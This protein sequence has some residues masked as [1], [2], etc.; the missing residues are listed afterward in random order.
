[1]QGIFKSILKSVVAIS[2][3]TLG[4]ISHAEVA[5][6]ALVKQTADEVLSI[7]KND[8]EIQAGNQKKLFALAEEKILPNFDFERVCK[9]VLGKNWRSANEEQQANFKKSF[10]ACYCVPMRL[11]FQNTEIKRLNTKSP[12]AHREAETAKAHRG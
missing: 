3:V 7:I 12:T 6:D 4:T 2:F 8:K 10:V 5:P 1:M 9:M 11:H